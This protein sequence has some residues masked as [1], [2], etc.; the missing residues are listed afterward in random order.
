MSG[1]P[2]PGHVEPRGGERCANPSRTGIL[3][4]VVSHGVVHRYIESGARHELESRGIEF[5]S[6]R[7][8]I[9]MLMDEDPSESIAFFRKCAPVS[10][11][12]LP[13]AP[14]VMEA[15]LS[16]KYWEQ[17]CWGSNGRSRGSPADPQGL[18][19]PSDRGLWLCRGTL[20]TVSEDVDRGAAQ[21]VWVNVESGGTDGPRA[22]ALRE[23]HE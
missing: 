2:P 19:A 4:T 20:G 13:E 8:A 23:Q 10:D 17:A 16:V 21:E 1:K 11:P 14:G 6:S 18:T 5:A 12:L 15:C 3:R 7:H 22:F 9:L